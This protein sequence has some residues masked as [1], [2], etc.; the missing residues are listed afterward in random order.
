LVVSVGIVIVVI[1]FWFRWNP[2]FADTI[3]D[4]ATLRKYFDQAEL[5]GK[6]A[7]QVAGRKTSNQNFK[8]ML[9]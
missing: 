3:R 8:A 7:P 9:T 1:I 4:L 2:S 6:F 5:S